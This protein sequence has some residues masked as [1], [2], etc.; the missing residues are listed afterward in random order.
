MCYN[1][2]IMNKSKETGKTS[3]FRIRG[4]PESLFREIKSEAA[5]S[6]L[7]MNDYLLVI[8]RKAM[9]KKSKV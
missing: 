7:S 9:E 8:V 2:L 1:D 4:I 6:G 5:L 3:D